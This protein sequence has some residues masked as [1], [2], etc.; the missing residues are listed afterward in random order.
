[1]AEKNVSFKLEAKDNVTGVLN[2]ITGSLNAMSKTSS[3][4]FK[5]VKNF[6]SAFQNF[7][8]A[9]PGM[10]LVAKALQVIAGTAKECEQAFSALQ[11]SEK[12]LD[13]AAGLNSSFGETATAFKKFTSDLSTE[14]NNT[15]S[16]GEI[17]S[18][19]TPL[20]YDKTAAQLKKLASVGADFSAAV[21]GNFSEATKKLNDTLSGEAGELAKLF[22]EIKAFTQEQ[23]KAGAAVDYVAEKVRGASQAMSDTVNGSMQRYKNSMGDLQEEIGAL[24]T[25]ALSPLRDLLASIASNWAAALGEAR[26]YKEA[27]VARENGT[28]DS[29]QLKLIKNEKMILYEKVN[30]E[31][32]NLVNDASKKDLSGVKGDRYNPANWN[33]LLNANEYSEK[34]A[35][36]AK[37]VQD[38]FN[39]AA[40]VEKEYVN[41]RKEEKEKAA[42]VERERLKAEEA[43]RIAAEQKIKAEIELAEKLLQIKNDIAAGKISEFEGNQI[44][45]DLTDRNYLQAQDLTAKDS[46]VSDSLKEAARAFIAAYQANGKLKES[47]ENKRIADEKAKKDQVYLDKLNKA[48]LDGMLPAERA[49]KEFADG[50]LGALLKLLRAKL[51]KGTATEEEED[52]YN[53]LRGKQD[54]LKA[55]SDKEQAE[56]NESPLVKHLGGMDSIIESLG[57]LGQ[58]LAGANPLFMFI[59]ALGKAILSIENVSKVLNFIDTIVSGIM[60][61]IEPVVNT[62]LQPLVGFLTILGNIIGQVILPFLQMLEP[63]IFPLNDILLSLLNILNP[64]AALFVVIMSILKPLLYILTPFLNIITVVVQALEWFAYK[65]IYPVAKYIAKVIDTVGNFFI[66]IVNGIIGALNEIPFVNISKINKLDLEGDVSAA[67]DRISSN[68]MAK[69]GGSTNNSG[70]S[71]G[72][73]F[74]AE[75]DITVNVNIY[76]DAI[77]GES[78]IRD[79]A[80][81]IR[82][83]LKDV[84]VLNMA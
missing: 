80:I 33:G 62:L 68:D 60:Q 9:V 20:A 6:V 18:A 39:E 27:A 29:D 78:G 51:A 21:T 12:R 17:Q 35:K 55:A 45:S 71:V 5:G 58:V 4:K 34:I 69:A 46:T 72:S 56:E 50:E 19:L 52:A 40:L 82:N 8:I 59:E 2:K 44:T 76:A 70:S 83:A 7:S 74:T 64:I 3:E 67:F 37:E 15:I 43:A 49:L 73:S 81:M 32:K 13:F 77:A 30:E 22:P 28:A 65:C 14:L 16:T 1:M 63:I 25:N 75:R 57:Q 48:I 61:V 84:D 42:Q 31:F 66:N 53:A 79:L 23:L 47:A 54:E 24:V 36:K 11:L 41:K 10:Q 38:L 26:R